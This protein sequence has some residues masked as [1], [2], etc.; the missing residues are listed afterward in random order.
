MIKP[1]GWQVKAFERFCESGKRPFLIDACPGAGKTKFS[2]ICAKHWLDQGRV[3]FVVVVV[4]TTAL[5]GTTDSGFLGSW[6]DVGVQ[7]TTVL[8]DGRGRPKDFAGGLVTYQ[9]LGNIVSTFKAWADGGVRLMFVFDEVHHASEANTWGQAVDACGQM[10]DKVLAMS[11]TPFRGDG[12]RISFVTY[13]ANDQAVPDAK[14]SYL[15]AVADNVCRPVEFMTDDGLAQYVLDEQEREIRISEASDEED[16]SHAARVIFKAE[17]DWLRS[18]IDKADERLDEYRAFDPNAGGIVICRPGKDENDDRH[19]MQV[20]K[21]VREVTGEM[22]E[23][24]THDDQDANAKIDNF[25]KGSTRWIC[26]VRKISEGVDIPRLRVMVMANRPGTELLF[27]QLVG[28][29]VRVEV[30]GIREDATVYLA[31]FPQLVEWAKQITEEAQS[32]IR[33]REETTREK[34]DGER[35]ESTFIPLSATHEDGGGVSEFGE[36][37]AAQE[38]NFA[39]RLKRGDPQM[40]G[41]PLTALAHIIRKLGVEIPV[42]VAPQEPLAVQK[43][44]LRKTLNSLA[45]S[46]AY[47][48]NPEKPDFAGVWSV[49]HRHTGAKSLDDL[50]D[51]QSIE[52]MRQVERLLRNQLGGGDESAVA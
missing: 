13:D 17:S 44:R 43:T 7:I 6:N 2:A 50:H 30:D 48:A 34:S 27:R 37:F 5:K 29:V 1:R 49:I 12:R 41:V 14:Y 8:K 39:E 45:R 4:P 51:N 33:Q 46:I 31:K 32:G 3:D 16:A 52:K 18:V 38:I 15:Q 25:R 28:R 36:T 26:S 10:A 35:G 9:Q 47:R 40:S 42:E 20:A 19:L 21:L 11:G 24:I 22:P 23:V